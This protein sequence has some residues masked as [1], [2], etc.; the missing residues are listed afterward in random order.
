MIFKDRRKFGGKNFYM[1]DFKSKYNI[2]TDR[3]QKKLPGK[4]KKMFRYT[5]VEDLETGCSHDS[6]IKDTRCS[7]KGPRFNS[8]YLHGSTQPSTTPVTGD[9]TWCTYLHAEKTPIHIK[10]NK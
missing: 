9:C 4:K 5:M 10:Q 6:V 1:G 8:H 3:K 7:C 2:Q